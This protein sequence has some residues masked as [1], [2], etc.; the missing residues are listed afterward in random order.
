M[1]SVSSDGGAI[2]TWCSS[3]ISAYETH[4]QSRVPGMHSPYPQYKDTTS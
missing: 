2:V 1:V 4:F 3:L